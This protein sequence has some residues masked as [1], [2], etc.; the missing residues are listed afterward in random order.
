MR[1]WRKF[2]MVLG[3][4]QTCEGCAKVTF[5]YN[6][7]KIALLISIVGYAWFLNGYDACGKCKFCDERGLDG[8][9]LSDNDFAIEMNRR[10]VSAGDVFKR[11][12][13]SLVTN[14][15]NFE[16]DLS[17]AVGV[18]VWEKRLNYSITK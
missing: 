10:C 14:D 7:F 17:N 18:L 16:E 3:E 15:T 5:Y 12:G 1:A 11:Y 4:H 9:K 6:L 2:R 8:F 13:D